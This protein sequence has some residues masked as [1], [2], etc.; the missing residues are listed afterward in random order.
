MKRHLQTV[1]ATVAI[2]AAY[3]GAGRFDLSLAIVNASAT[4]VWPPT[5]IAFAFLL[6]WGYR[7]WPAVFLGAFLVNITTQG[8][9]WTTLGI[10][11][12]NTMEALMGVW[13]VNQFADGRHAFDQARSVFKYTLLAVIVSTAVSATLGTTSLVQRGFTGW[14]NYVP[15]W[16]TW[17]LGDAVGALI[18]TPLIVI[19]S[20]LRFSRWS[21]QR[22][23]EGSAIFVAVLLVSLITFGNRWDA[24]FSRYFRFLLYPTALWAAYRFG[25]C[26]AISAAFS[27]ECQNRGR[28][29]RPHQRETQFEKRNRADLFRRP[30]GG[31][32]SVGIQVN[33]R[34][35][36]NHR[37][38]ASIRVQ[39][40]EVLPSH[41]LA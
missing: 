31:S 5:G 9:L 36:M 15:I 23:V 18:I 40:L 39:S 7:L 8:T 2:A 34:L 11:T 19:W 24:A 16:T 35:S 3:F 14:N 28:A 38:M 6:L 30:V 10:A 26:G 17:W 13:L 4:A 20:A 41:D 21:R 1:A 12:G 25:Q 33:H 32:A 22:I 37:F 27:L 29:P